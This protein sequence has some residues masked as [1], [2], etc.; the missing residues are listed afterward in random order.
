MA[1]KL[2]DDE[3]GLILNWIVDRNDRNV[4]SQVCKQWLRVEG[5]TRRS[6]RIFEPE[7]LPNLLPRFPNLLSLEST[8]L[9]SNTNLKFI[10]QNCP[11]LKTL[12]L[13][14]KQ[15]QDL[16]VYDDSLCDDDFGDK[17][18]CFLANWCRNLSKVL[19]RRRINVGFDGVIAVV[20]QSVQNL[21]VLDLGRCNL[22]NDQV[23]EAVAGAHSIRVLIFNGC[24][25]IT[26]MGLIAL[27]TGLASKS[28][29]TLAMAECDRIT[30]SGV[31]FLQ[32]MCCL[33]VLILAECGPKVTDSGTITVARIASLKR[34]NLSWLINV[35]DFTLMAIAEGCKS[36]ERI[37]L[38]GC[39]LITVDGI[40]ALRNLERLEAVVLVFCYNICDVDLETLRQCKSL[41]YAVLSKDVDTR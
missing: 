32:R 6:I 31:S 40:R 22:I 29:K 16:D 34:L 28:L 5:Q 24:S 7:S 19:L 8:T 23:L 26:D 15:R 1:T 3:V 35:S 13:N 37:D 33:E 18:L 14:L 4:S 9:I 11:K 38:T 20:N 17:G 10:A 39:E 21:T 30:D 2:G 41:R 27:S 36:L 25:L 12:N